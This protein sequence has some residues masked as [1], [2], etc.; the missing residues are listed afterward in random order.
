MIRRVLEKFWNKKEKEPDITEQTVFDEIEEMFN[1]LGDN[2]IKILLGEDLQEFRDEIGNKIKTLRSEIKEECGFILPPVNIQTHDNLQENEY[3][4]S[5]NGKVIFYDFII[6]T[7]ENAL[8]EIIKGLKNSFHEN[9]PDFF[10]NEITERYA[11]A[12][13]KNNGW[14]AW[15]VTGSMPIT[16]LK[17]ILID[18][19]ENKQ[20]INN[21]IDIFE[22]I[23]EEIFSNPTPAW[24]RDPHEISQKI[25]QTF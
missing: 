8:K 20:P 13:Q 18:L 11:C 10:T 7:E 5:V 12:V 6:P 17:A 19:L 23:N 15:N 24:T 1:S 22:R 16:S 4:I 3:K 14:L 9:V 2:E 21:I 25:L